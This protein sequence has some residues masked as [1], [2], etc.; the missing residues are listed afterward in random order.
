MGHRQFT[1]KEPYMYVLMFQ[2]QGNS[3]MCLCFNYM[4]KKTTR[5]N[6]MLACTQ[7]VRVLQRTCSNKKI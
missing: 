1:R 7:N 3:H 4:Y 6:T 5:Y 2:L